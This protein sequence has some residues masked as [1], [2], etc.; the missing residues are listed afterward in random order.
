MLEEGSG[1]MKISTESFLPL[2]ILIDLQ[3]GRGGGQSNRGSAQASDS[4]GHSHVS[5][6]IK[7]I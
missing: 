4:D 3:G 6:A 2:R 7:F 1:S 5:G